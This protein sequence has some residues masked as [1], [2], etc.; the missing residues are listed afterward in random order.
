MCSL[1]SRPTQY[2]KLTQKHTQYVQESKDI[3]AVQPTRL[4]LKVYYR[5]FCR[6]ILWDLELGKVQHQVKHLKWGWQA[7]GIAPCKGIQ[8][9]L[10]FWIPGTGFQIFVSGTWIQDSN[11]QWDSRSLELYSGFHKPKISRVPESGLDSGFQLLV[12]FRIPRA[13]FR[14]PN[15]KAQDCRLH[16]QKFFGFRNS[17]FPY[18]GGW[19]WR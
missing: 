14:I 4:I 2:E 11:R 8:A 7:F 6:G 9:N 18:K 3:V 17:G 19:E 1:K 15:S 5:N 10:G 12:G 13:L 16:K